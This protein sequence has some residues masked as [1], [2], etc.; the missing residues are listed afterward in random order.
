MSD[1]PILMLT[2]YS[3]QEQHIKGLELGADDY[4]NKPFDVRE[5]TLRVGQCYAAHRAARPAPNRLGSI[6][7][8]TTGIS[9]LI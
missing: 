4:V 8:T 5:L 3:G 7:A 1:I 2:A 9:S 6:I